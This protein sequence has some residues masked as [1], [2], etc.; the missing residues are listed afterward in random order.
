MDTPEEHLTICVLIAAT[1][2]A[3]V[4][5]SWG[6]L[7][8]IAPV[9]QLSSEPVA[10]TPVLTTASSENQATSSGT[11]INVNIAT[12]QELDTL[13][14]IGPAKAAAIVAYRE[15]NGPFQKLEDLEQVSGISASMIES[16]ADLATAEVLDTA[17]TD[18]Q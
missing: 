15:E 12:A 14:G 5:I 1:A 18:T 16:W 17:L 4:V 13:P 6:A 11:H 7:F 2:V 9:W 8:W 10:Y 3:L